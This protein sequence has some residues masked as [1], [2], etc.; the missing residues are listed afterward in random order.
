MADMAQKLLLALALC[1]NFSIF[2][3]EEL[4]SVAET[5]E[6]LAEPV[7]EPPVAVTEKDYPKE[8]FE[9]KRTQREFPSAHAIILVPSPSDMVTNISG[10]R[11]VVVEKG[12]FVPGGAQGLQ[13]KL[14]PIYQGRPVSMG[15][16]S[17]LKTT[18]QSYYHDEGYPFVLVELPQQEISEGVIQLVVLEGHL[19]RVTVEGVRWS[20]PSKLARTIS[21][22]RGRPIDEDQLAYDLY[23]INRNMFRQ[24]NVLYKP[25]AQTNDVDIV[26]KMQERRVARIYVGADN[27]GVETTGEERLYTGINWG[28][29]WGLGHV[30][31]YQYTTDFDFNRFQAHTVQYFAPLPNKH[32]LDIYG[33]Y[34][35]VCPTTP[36]GPGNQRSSREDGFSLQTSG[37][38]LIPFAISRHLQ[39]DWIFG[40]D[41]KRTNN[42][43]EFTSDVDQA[44]RGD[45]VNL[46][47]LVTGFAGNY[48]QGHT[49]LDWG[50]S[51][52]GSPGRW[53]ADQSDADYRSLRPGAENQWIYARSRFVY[54]QQIP[55]RWIFWLSTQGQVSSEN[56]L[57]SEQFGLGG[58]DTVRGY[59]EREENKDNAMLFNFEIRA[60]QFSPFSAKNDDALQ[61]ILF[62]DFGWGINWRSIAGEPKS[63]YLMG[64]GP[65]VRY[66]WG[67]IFTGFL[68][69]GIKLHHSDQFSH[70]FS[71]LHFGATFSY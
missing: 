30:F 24:A 22:P 32:V 26:L 34:S 42:T 21:L 2:A 16:I 47:Q 12:V 51:F 23:Y 41:F 31:S 11:G 35:T 53:L 14:A 25:G 38:Y 55:G 46:F 52:F 28:N 70:Q 39:N 61:F 59:E 6:H 60:P 8:P 40:A 4:E 65:G 20:N 69:W 68:D 19:G 43:A 49:R 67:T 1:F 7:T 3:Q 64:I 54:L 63:S 58:Y 13:K 17:E 45:N 5:T 66:T 36:D 9:V 48:Q 62:Y 29:V 71:R 50:L 44:R 15:M 57:P 56:L 27:T 10:L 37:R 33:G 18:V